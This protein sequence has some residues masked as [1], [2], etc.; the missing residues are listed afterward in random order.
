M[1]RSADFVVVAGGGGGDSFFDE[2][3]DLVFGEGWPVFVEDG[4]HGAVEKADLA[5]WRSPRAAEMVA[6]GGGVFVEEDGDVW[7]VGLGEA[8]D[9]DAGALGFGNGLAAFQRLFERV[10]FVAG[11]SDRSD[12][13]FVIVICVTKIPLQSEKQKSVSETVRVVGKFSIV[14]GGV[15]AE[16][17]AGVFNAM[18]V[19]VKEVERHHGKPC[20]R[21]EQ[22]GEEK[23]EGGLE[24]GFAM[25]AHV[26][27]TGR[28][29]SW[30]FERVSMP[31]L[32]GLR[33]LKFVNYKHAG[34]S[35]PWRAY[36][37]ETGAIYEMQEGF[38]K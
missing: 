19:S 26:D 36:A 27:W 33:V 30:R 8:L 35:G 4:F 10:A 25:F 7:V 37:I 38:R 5:K 20:G 21:E 32:R 15:Y 28:M 29:E 22:R 16:S 13:V 34:P 3:L 12:G 11:A 2:E 31:P 18:F 17:E 24:Q 1:T 9:V 6:A 23:Y 14:I